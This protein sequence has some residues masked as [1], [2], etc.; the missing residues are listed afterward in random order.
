LREKTLGHAL[1]V[2]AQI[3]PYLEGKNQ[4]PPANFKAKRSGREKKIFV[5]VGP[6]NRRM[7]AMKAVK[8]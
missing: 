3:R 5:K 6:G 1:E 2:N 4:Q 8:G 7:V